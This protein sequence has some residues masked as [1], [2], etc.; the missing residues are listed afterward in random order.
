MSLYNDLLA[1]YRKYFRPEFLNRVDDI[2]VFDPISQTT[3][4]HIVDVQLASFIAMVKKEKD[5]D[6]TITNTAKDELGLV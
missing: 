4:R 5:I 6:L 2:I 1:E 3:L